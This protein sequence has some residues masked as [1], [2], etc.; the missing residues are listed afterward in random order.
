MGQ[1]AGREEMSHF[2][3]QLEVFLRKAISRRT[4][5]KYL[6]GGLLIFISENRI[7]KAV[8]ADAPAHPPRIKKD[9]KTNK[10]LAMISGLD[11]YQNTVAAVEALGG[12]SRFVKP[13]AVVVIKPNMSWDRTPEQGANTE[14]QVVAALVEMCYKA[15][16]KRVNIF[17]VTCNDSRRAYENSGIQKAAQKKG[18]FVYFADTW[19]VV[20]AR[21]PYPS[22]ME[23]WPILRDAVIC[24]TFI[25]VPVLKNHDLTGLS[26]SMKNLMGVCGGMRGQMHTQMGRN[27]ADLAAFIQPELTVIDATRV[28]MRNGPS[29]GNLEDVVRVDKVIAS[30][31]FVLA[32]AF[33]ATLVKINPMSISYIKSAVEKNLGNADVAK[34]NIFLGKA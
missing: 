14:P 27:L 7:L 19:N 15:G 34:A 13:N 8:F 22:S 29:G 25:N 31:D 1:H 23:N 11:P 10:H 6:L 2:F 26:L 24:D 18:A 33:A 16:A 20:G 12:M 5:L 17:D 32:D 3:Y 4:F 30:G 9:I 21:Y 28:L